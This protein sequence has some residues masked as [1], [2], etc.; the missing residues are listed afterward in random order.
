MISV[1]VD[2][3]H[4]PN[5][6]GSSTWHLICVSSSVCYTANEALKTFCPHS[7]RSH[8]S[9]DSLLLPHLLLFFFPFV[10]LIQ[11]VKV[12]AAH[13]HTLWAMPKAHSVQLLI[14]QGNGGM[15]SPYY[16]LRAHG[17]TGGGGWDRGEGGGTSGERQKEKKISDRMESKR[18]TEQ[19]IRGK[20]KRKREMEER[21]TK[22]DDRFSDVSKWNLCHGEMMNGLFSPSLTHLRYWSCC[23]HS[24]S[25]PH[26]HRST[27]DIPSMECIKTANSENNHC[28]P[29]NNPS[30]AC[31]E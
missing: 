1:N 20:K 17:K 18:K 9:A 7:F 13:T 8:S 3:G 23:C 5:W 14:S 28:G 31:A 25:H 10:S 16:L 27:Q 30:Y 29:C 11:K 26:L 19:K 21:K 2:C 22:S 12:L 4:L 15:T 24:P 6:V